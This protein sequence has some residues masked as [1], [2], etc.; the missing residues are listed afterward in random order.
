MT[1]FAEDTILVT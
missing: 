1:R